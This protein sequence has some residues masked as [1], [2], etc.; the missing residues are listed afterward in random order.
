MADEA[1]VPAEAAAE[2]AQEETP[3]EVVPESEPAQDAAET[4]AEAPPEPKKKSVQERIDE[5]TR[6]RRG[7][8]REREYWKRV[9]LEREQQRPQESAPEMLNKPPR[10]TLDQYETTTAY[11]DAL[12]RWHDSVR[13]IDAAAR[14]EQSERE[15]ALKLFNER[16]RKIREENADFDEVIEQPVFSPI[17]RGV[18]LQSENGPEVAYFLGRPENR[19]QAERIRNLPA[20]RQAYEIGKLESNLLLAKKTKKIPGAPPPINPVGIGGGIK[21]KDPSEMSVEEWM[22]WDRRNQEEKIKRKYGG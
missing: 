10:P 16:A 3:A 9:A 15:T 19:D 21:E 6:A 12:F 2:P 11:E 4:T 22:L 7:A 14:R 20:E 17:M 8:E 18:L 1:V 5:I 13:E